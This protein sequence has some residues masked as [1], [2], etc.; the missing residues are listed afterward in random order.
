MSFK[1]DTDFCRDGNFQHFS[2]TIS[3]PP[4]MSHPPRMSVL[5]KLPKQFRNLFI[6]QMTSL[7]VSSV[8][9]S[10][11]AFRQNG[12]LDF[13]DFLPAEVHTLLNSFI[14]SSA[15][16]NPT[17]PLISQFIS[18]IQGS[19][20]DLDFQLLEY[21]SPVYGKS[22]FKLQATKKGK[23]TVLNNTTHPLYEK[24]DALQKRVHSDKEY[25]TTRLT[26]P[27]KGFYCPSALSSI[28]NKYAFFSF[29]YC[30]DL[31]LG[32]LPLWPLDTSSNFQLD[33]KDPMR[34]YTLDNVRWLNKPDNVA[35]KPSTGAH[36]KSDFNKRKDVV[37][38]LH[39]CERS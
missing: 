2:S 11:L 17:I 24:W 33:R 19:L 13:D 37:K 1:V 7:Q 31:F 3:L 38:L 16:K 12:G 20:L 28:R 39:N 29:V 21:R 18:Y 10:A 32:A 14:Y 27:W 6:G 22:P 35:N 23:Q 25:S 30:M 34:H 15:F 9:N 8:Q 26:F 4:G 36:S 5:R